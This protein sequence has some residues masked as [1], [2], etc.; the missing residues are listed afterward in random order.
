[1]CT[2]AVQRGQLCAAQPLTRR[3]SEQ[4]Q[5]AVAPLFLLVKLVS[6]HCQQVLVAWEGTELCTVGIQLKHALLVQHS[7]AKLSR[8]SRQSLKDSA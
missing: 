7:H 1:M 3:N 5:A 6:A 4:I 8:T 2:C